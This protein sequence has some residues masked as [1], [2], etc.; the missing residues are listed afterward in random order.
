MNFVFT[1]KS[2][3]K[4]RKSDRDEIN[5]IVHFE[6]DGVERRISTWILFTKLR[7]C[8]FFWNFSKKVFPNLWWS[9]ES[10]YLR[11]ARLDF[12]IGC[13]T[14]SCGCFLLSSR[15]FVLFSL[16]LAISWLTI[17]SDQR[18]LDIE[19][20]FIIVDINGW[21]NAVAAQSSPCLRCLVVLSTLRKW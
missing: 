13:S 4:R 18:C 15:S 17:R 6:I 9:V 19:H 8:S 16:L 1:S 3:K 2:T 21:M 14:M 12:L 7:G 20:S 11:V 10:T 5:S